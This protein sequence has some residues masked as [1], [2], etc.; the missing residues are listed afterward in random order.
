MNIIT[1]KI[2][3]Q[4]TAQELKTSNRGLSAGN[5]SLLGIKKLREQILELAVR[6]KLVPQDPDNEPASE[7]LK[8]IA[9][10]KARQVHEGK[11]KKQ[12]PLPEISDDEKP[13]E[14]PE[15]WEMVRLKEL[16]YFYGGGTPSKSKS[17]YWNG[18]ILWVSPKDMYS[19]ILKILNLR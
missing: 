6:G 14:L 1:N 4:T 18:D 19:E 13:F 17:N 7:L 9:R 12:A 15:G 3:L 11:I 2:D 10:E 16:G 5:Q 8:K